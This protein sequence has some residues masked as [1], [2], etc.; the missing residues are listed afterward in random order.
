M[1]KKLP[2][3]AEELRSKYLRGEVSQ[4]I[5]HSNIYDLILYEGKWL[6]FIDFLSEVLFKENKELI[7]HYNLSTGVKF[8]KKKIQIPSLDDFLLY[9]S[10]EK[11]LPNFEKLINSYNKVA[12]IIDYAEMIVPEGDTNFL[13]E[14]DRTNIVTLHRWSL[15]RTLEQLDNV[16]VLV[17]ENLSNLNQRIVSNPK[18]GAIKVPLP[19]LEER[20]RIISFLDSSMS[21]KEI[22]RFASLTSGL[23]AIQIKGILSPQ[24]HSEDDDT[25]RLNFIKALLG[26]TPD[27]EIRAEKFANLTQGMSFEEIKNLINP[28][29]VTPETISNPYENILNILLKRKREIIE[30]ECFGLIE[31]VDTEHN[32]SVVGGME[33]I[34][35][36]LLKIAGYIKGGEKNR[37]PMGLLFTGPM[38]TGKTFIAEAFAKESGLTGIKFKNFRSKWVGATESNLEKILSVVKAIGQVLIIIDEVDRSFGTSQ[39]G[40]EGTTSRVIARLKEFMSDTEN[41]GNI[42]FILMSNRPDKLD[43]DIK[44]AGRLDRKIPFFYADDPEEIESILKA[45]AKKNKVNIEIEF[46]KDREISNK[47]LGYSNA[48]LEAI[49]LL[50]NDYAGEDEGVVKVKHLEQAINDYLP[51]RDEKMLEYMELLAVFESSS[52]KLLPKKY[53]DV[54]NKELQERLSLLQRELRRI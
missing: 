39:E 4:F 10:P 28:L 14:A 53:R 41:R 46:P 30:K 40:D 31:F 19:D 1:G 16:I 7:I 23:K 27:S 43:V 49:L 36:E 11:I 26:N 3:W 32:F 29:G 51:S 20:K 24:T 5:L 47:L 2:N 13:S 8:K 52:R 42:L 48:D 9:K 44:R 22:D 45:Q 12:L 35:K 15:D 21:P 25:G 34:K 54:S 38:G 50:A 18:V 17:T 6:S 33:E 37:V